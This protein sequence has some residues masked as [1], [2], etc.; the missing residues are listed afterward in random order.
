MI[1]LKILVKIIISLLIPVICF[2]CFIGNVAIKLSSYLI[3]P[4]I[5]F[6]LICSV[7]AATQSQWLQFGLLMGISGAA[8]LV[9]L[10][11]SLVVS[12]VEG[13]RDGMVR[14]INS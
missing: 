11:S 8:F 13:A 10:C 3:G 7:Y 12:A 9:S 6:C 2:A 4:F 14:F 5:L 1:I